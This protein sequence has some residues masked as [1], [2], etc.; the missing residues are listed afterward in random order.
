MNVAPLHATRL[1]A[2]VDVLCDAFAEYPVMRFVAGPDAED[3]DRRLRSLIHFFTSARFLNG[4]LVL[5]AGSGSGET[6]VAVAN[7]TPPGTRPAAP[8]VSHRRE[9]LWRELGADARE[10]YEQL[11]RIWQPLGIERPHYH[12]NMIGVRRDW[13]GRGA[14]R[15]LLDAVHALSADSP[16]SCGVSLTT[17]D[18]INVPL[19]QHVGYAITGHAVVAPGLE[20][21]GFFRPDR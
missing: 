21:W 7:V 8:E 14:G 5:G 4:D 9:A 12:L 3:Y 18:P 1:E 17:E 2:A 19:Y 10:R 11:G 20:T 15:L 16:E 6:L 13:R